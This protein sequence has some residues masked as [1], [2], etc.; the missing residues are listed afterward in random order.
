VNRPEPYLKPEEVTGDTNGSTLDFFGV[1]TSADIAHV[2][3]HI[4]NGG[5]GLDDLWIGAASGTQEVPEPGT[6]A[7]LA[8]SAVAGLAFRRRKS[9]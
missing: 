9:A 3:I 8:G 5:W 4:V 6:M 1:T 2:K 7:M